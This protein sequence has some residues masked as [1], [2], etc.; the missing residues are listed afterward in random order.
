[1]TMKIDFTGKR[2]IICGG[3]RGI[4]KAVAMG[5]A[6]CGGA[7]SIC[8]RNP[9]ILEQTRAEIAAYGNPT[10]ALAADLAEGAAV[11]AYVTSATEVLGGVDFLVNNATAFR[12]S[13]DEQG[14][15][16]TLALDLLPIVHAT[17]AALPALRESQGSVLNMSSLAAFLPSARQPAY[18]AIKA[19]VNHYTKTQAA[20][21]AKDRIRVNSI[22]PGA[23]EFPGGL[24]E[25]RKKESPELY[26][27]ILA[28]I[29]FGRM[30]QAEEIANVG[31]FLASPLA[32]WVTG[33]TITVA[34]AQGL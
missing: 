19:A 32:S 20:M 15:M 18:A 31:L 22:A 5:F 23:V 33:Q 24:W 8:A 2:A 4:G 14:W 12:T 26:E 17:Q 21:Y 34:G 1:M 25:R 10:H 7:V 30:A 6:A 3:S 29:P 16:D 9:E 11:R 13:D 28:T 27:G